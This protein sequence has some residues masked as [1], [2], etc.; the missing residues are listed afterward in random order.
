MCKKTRV[1]LWLLAG[2]V[3]LPA[4]A[5]DIQPL[6]EAF[7]LFLAGGVE[8]DGEWRDPMSLLE[9]AELSEVPEERLAE[10]ESAEALN[11]AQADGEDNE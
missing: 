6:D 1:S 2:C 4:Q 8:V 3:L 10:V 7:L 11:E 5:Q 9:M